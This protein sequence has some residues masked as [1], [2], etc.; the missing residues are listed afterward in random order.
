MEEPGHLSKIHIRKSI[1]I[2]LGEI[3]ARCG[4]QVGASYKDAKGKPDGP[5]IR[6]ML[7]VIAACPKPLRD[8]LTP[9]LAENVRNWLRFIGWTKLPKNSR[10]SA[11]EDGLGLE[12]MHVRAL[13]ASNP[14]IELDGRYT[15]H[16]YFARK[17]PENAALITVGEVKEEDVLS[18]D[19]VVI[20]EVRRLPK[21]IA[22]KLKPR[23]RRSG[24]KG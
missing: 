21:P 16:R 17:L 2:D 13:L 3:F 15:D 11:T 5:Y 20:S 18:L 6:F 4:G 8:Y 22:D 23:N 1:Y 10:P 7:A 24:P 12:L 19:D 14:N 9:N